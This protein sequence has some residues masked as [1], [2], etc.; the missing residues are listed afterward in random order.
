MSDFDTWNAI[1]FRMNERRK[2]PEHMLKQTG[3]NLFKSMDSVKE[4][5]YLPNSF[6]CSVILALDLYEARAPSELAKLRELEKKS[7]QQ[8]VDI[9]KPQPAMPPTKGN[10]WEHQDNSDE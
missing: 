7:R 9:I 3:S 6:L 4:N 1:I 2:P 8:L 5:V 10:F